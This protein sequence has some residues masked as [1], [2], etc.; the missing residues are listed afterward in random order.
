MASF[1]TENSTN[2]PRSSNSSSNISNSNNNNQ[3]E[4]P[5]ILLCDFENHNKDGG[6]WTLLDG[7]IYDV[8]DFRARNPAEFAATSPE[9][10]DDTEDQ[11]QRSSSSTNAEN[12]AIL[13][14]EEY[15]TKIENR[16][17]LASFCVGVLEVEDT[18]DSEEDYFD[19]DDGSE[20]GDY[21]PVYEMDLKSYSTPFLDMERNL[22]FLLGY[23]NHRLYQSL[24]LQ[25]SEMACSNV[26]ESTFM[27]GG[28]NAIFKV[29]PFNEDKVEE[30]VVTSHSSSVGGGGECPVITPPDVSTSPVVNPEDGQMTADAE[31]ELELSTS[32][33]VDVD[34]VS[35]FHVV[36]KLAENDLS[37][38]YVRMFLQRVEGICR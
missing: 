12:E 15:A 20:D 36:S 25:A 11:D 10:R 5:T 35:G 21:D 8:Q 26:V 17:S 7:K 19:E 28:L 29:D 23:S 31:A 6:L 4:L 9:S 33:N 37:D 18:D 38:P 22:A 3:N 32:N 13:K 1:F 16:E 24:P 30:V 2:H 27:K 14:F 34:T